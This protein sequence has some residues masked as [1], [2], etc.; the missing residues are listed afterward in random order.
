MKHMLR[1]AAFGKK[2]SDPAHFDPNRYVNV[3]K[4]LIVLAKLR[5]S[6]VCNRAI[7]C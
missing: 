5:H 7:T 3:V 4:H 2:F 1:T 6:K